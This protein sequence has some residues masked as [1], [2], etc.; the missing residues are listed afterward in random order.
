[1][2]KGLK[3]GVGVG[4]VVIAE[5]SAGDAQDRMD[6]QV[7]GL[8][9]GEQVVL[10]PAHVTGELGSAAVGS[11]QCGFVADLRCRDRLRVAGELLGETS[12]LSGAACPAA[13]RRLSRT[14]AEK[15]QQAEPRARHAG[16]SFT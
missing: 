6:D 1:M 12:P 8:G 16:T 10:A 4:G 7:G 3:H 14:S 2:V 5:V 11:D 15:P 13:A 9:A